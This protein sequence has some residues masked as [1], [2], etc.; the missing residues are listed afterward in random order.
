MN[1]SFSLSCVYSDIGGNGIVRVLQKVDYSIIML[2][3][4][5][6]MNR[7]YHLTTNN[8][9]GLMGG[10]RTTHFGCVFL[11][12]PVVR[13]SCFLA[14]MKPNIVFLSI[15]K[16]SCAKILSIALDLRFSEKG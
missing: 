5:C 2:Q 16:K 15:S 11:Y 8:S 10:S 6:Y 1:I 4:M 12:D 7:L 3:G 14:E 13:L 9:T